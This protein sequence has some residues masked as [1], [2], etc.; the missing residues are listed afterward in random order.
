MFK[1][2]DMGRAIAVKRWTPTALECYKR[3]CVCEGCFYSDFFSATAQKCQ[4]KAAVLELVRTIGTPNVE[5][6]QTINPYET[7]IYSRTGITSITI[8][9]SVTS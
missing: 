7:T 2:R 1:S 5:L 8:P 4:M 6:P 3:G 9:D